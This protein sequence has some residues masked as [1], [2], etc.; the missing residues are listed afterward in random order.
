[1]ILKAGTLVLI[2]GAMQVAVPVMRVPPPVTRAPNAAVAP[3]TAVQANILPD[4][5]VSEVRIEDDHT[6]HIRITNQGT[7]DV[8][9]SF[10]VEFHCVARVPRWEH[11]SRIR[12][13]PRRRREQMGDQQQLPGPRGDLCARQGHEHAAADGDPI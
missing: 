12:H 10:M 2:A 1:M 8:K 5:V 13:R 4:L 7:A 11:R 3:N 6:A 9:G